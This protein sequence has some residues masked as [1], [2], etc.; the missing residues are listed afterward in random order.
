VRV[1]GDTA[2][3]LGIVTYIS[4]LLQGAADDVIRSED[5]NQLHSSISSDVGTM[6]A[7][8]D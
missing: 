6:A 7:K 1:L 3:L 8:I 2:L 5:C 4:G